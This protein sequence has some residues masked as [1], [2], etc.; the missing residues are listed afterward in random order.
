MT[1]FDI[2]QMRLTTVQRDTIERLLDG[3][4]KRLAELFNLVHD[5]L[6]VYAWCNSIEDVLSYF[7]DCITKTEALCIVQL[8]GVLKEKYTLKQN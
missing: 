5:N 2:K 8:Y 7:K 1:Q 6:E 4:Y 3:N